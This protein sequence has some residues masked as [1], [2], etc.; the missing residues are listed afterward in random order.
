MKKKPLKLQVLFLFIFC[1][2]VVLFMDKSF[3]FQGGHLPVRTEDSENPV[4][5][6]SAAPSGIKEAMGIYFF[7]AWMWLSIF[8]L[9]Y[10]LRLKIKEADRLFKLKFFSS[11]KT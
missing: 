10:I 7:I 3:G 8:I 1:L 11:K 9:V 2:L 6:I 4:E 5:K